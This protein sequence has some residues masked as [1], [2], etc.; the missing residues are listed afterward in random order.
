MLKS[1]YELYNLFHL[2]VTTA[3]VIPSIDNQSDLVHV[4][5]VGPS[6][7]EYLFHVDRDFVFLLKMLR[8]WR[9]ISDQ[10]VIL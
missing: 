6:D 5:K 9:W 7:D 1:I 4:E 10:F 8:Y 3:N 2:C